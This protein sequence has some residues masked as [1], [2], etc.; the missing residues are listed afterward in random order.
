[1][2][3]CL[4]R[5]A[6]SRAIRIGTQLPHARGRQRRQYT[7]RHT[8]TTQRTVRGGLL[9]HRR[10]FSASAPSSLLSH[11]AIAEVG[12]SALLVRFDTEIDTEANEAALR[13]LASLEGT[14]G[15][16][17]IVDLIPAYA[18]LTILFDPLKT[19][20]EALRQCCRDAMA[21]NPPADAS[22]SASVSS[23]SPSSDSVS[24]SGQA[25][26]VEIP[27]EYGGE[28][29]PDL[30]QAAILTGM[31]EQEIVAAH[32]AELYRVFF[33]GFTAGFPYLGGLTEKLKT[34]PRL[35]SPRTLVP[36][37]SVGV[38][39]GQTGVYTVDSPGGWHILGQTDTPLFDPSSDPP[40]LL[41][42]G[43]RVRFVPRAP[44]SKTTSPSSSPPTAELTQPSRTPE[45]PW[46]EV[47]NPGAL[48]S[49]QDLGRRGFGRHGVSVSGAA[50]DLALR[51]GNALVG[52]SASCAA[53]ECLFGGMQLRILQDCVVAVTGADCT[54]DLSGVP[55][56]MR[57][58]T[59][60]QAGTV[61]KLGF[62]LNGARS[63]VCVGGG[64][65]GAKVLGSRSVDVRAGLG[66]MTRPLHT[67]DVVGRGKQTLPRT[68]SLLTIPTDPLTKPPGSDAK[69]GATHTIR[70]LPGPGDPGMAGDGAGS[71]AGIREQ[72]Q[73]LASRRFEVDERSDRMGVRL[74]LDPSS[75]SAASAPPL[76]GGQVMSEGV[77]R[78]TIQL[79]PDGN[80][81]V[82]LADHQTTGGYK[83][84]AV[85]ISADLW[86]VAQFRPGDTVE[87]V[88]STTEEATKALVELRKLAESTQVA[89]G[90]PTYVAAR[91]MEGPPAAGVW[92]QSNKGKRIDLNADAGEG[93]DDEG[94]FDVV[95]SANIACGGHAG[96]AAEL[97]PVIAM[98]A[99]KGVVVGA[100]VS[101]EDRAGFGRVTLDTP[102]DVLRAQVIWQAAALDGLCRAH[103]TRVRYMK[104]HGALY[105]TVLKG[106]PQ[107]VAVVEAAGI[108]GLP[109][110]LMPGTPW[111]SITEGFAERTYD[112]D[113]L[114]PRNLPNA[115]IECP[116]EAAVQA[117][118]LAE[119][120]I[121]SICI[122]GDSAG[123]VNIARA[124]RTH[125]EAQG[126]HIRSMFT[127]KSDEEHHPS[128]WS[129]PW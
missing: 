128:L 88:P 9:C 95:T 86:R 102:P 74:R 65:G 18:S 4:R 44:D 77:A 112:G 2:L 111:G 11:P 26:V 62:P 71:R 67:G 34:I 116:D 31:T 61:L 32:S 96:S 94:L 66:A 56:P 60:A 1:M 98:A 52:N 38:A 78:G 43:D 68:T 101:Y 13:L 100:Q 28:A 33:L 27:V 36:R 15:P 75:T 55:V 73:A 92:A 17:G 29:G 39:A 63:Y 87:F 59:L 80:P 129:E 10:P 91:L 93:F 114:R 41:R 3:V 126:W 119:K 125:L 50:D 90:K 115:L 84:P 121:E 49:I 72:L 37:G 19:T 21:S 16:E 23:S 6:L 48:S 58:A 45:E 14:L 5:H 106:G 97:D 124:V 122:H 12:D 54:P 76:V 107:A 64:V 82:L 113:R 123:A 51:M 57:T 127:E 118:W 42:A 46:M 108:L 20:A 109:L 83:V 120:G 8:T 110:L 89:C 47:D 40:A 104:P 85:V 81:V 79:P 24:T 105:H 30:A 22:V 69:S 70:V 117:Q 53:L 7:A 103:G 35:D 99:R 25:R